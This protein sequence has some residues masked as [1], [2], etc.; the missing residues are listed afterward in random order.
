MEVMSVTLEVSHEPISW[1]NERESKTPPHHEAPSLQSRNNLFM[2]V[3]RLVSQLG[4]SSHPAA[5]HRAELGSAQFESVEQQF[6]PDV[7]FP[8]Q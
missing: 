2:S 8:R 4:M 5:P 7:T 6:A 1:L 3:T